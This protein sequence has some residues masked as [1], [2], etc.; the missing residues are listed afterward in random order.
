[1]R[2]LL[3]ELGLSA[4]VLTE[5]GT[6][7]E[8][9]VASDAVLAQFSTAVSEAIMLDRPTIVVDILRRGGYGASPE[10]DAALVALDADDVVVMLRRV[11][12][13]APTRETLAAA[14]SKYVE[15]HFLALDGGASRR[16]ATVVVE[17]TGQALPAAVAVRSPS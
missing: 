2:A 17:A 7:A 13:D 11:L 12:D 6:L 15:D 9:V 1:M 16:V 8:L 5:S 4:A 14:R 3:A 10:S